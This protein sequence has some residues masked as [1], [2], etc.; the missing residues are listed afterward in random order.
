MVKMM[1]HVGKLK[2]T[3]TRCVV[4]LMQIP[5]KEDHALIVESDS[6]PDHYH[7]NLM[8]VLESREGQ[9]Q[10]N[11]ADE[12]ARKMM[13]IASRGNMPVLQALH[14][15]K[16]LRAESVDNITMVPAPGSA[17]PLRQILESMGNLKPNTDT[18]LDPRNNPNNPRFNP[19]THNLEGNTAKDKLE[20]AKGIIMQAQLMEADAAKLRA[21]AYAIAPELREQYGPV[22]YV[23]A[24]SNK[25][26][27]TLPAVDN[28]DGMEMIVD[29]DPKLAESLM[30]L[31][32]EVS[33]T[34]KK[35]AAKQPNKTGTKP[36]A[37]R[38]PSRKSTA[39]KTTK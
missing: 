34:M 20:A 35:P 31:T 16:F 10:T 4:V 6:L 7:Q 38:A 9:N 39:P 36:A 33:E 23:Q 19:H 32:E 24:S 3:D 2:A 1:R 29:T 27:E 17:H 30:Q 21:Q 11:L 5:N 26:S 12:L 13:F 22:S 28:T 15:A 18:V 37:K 25:M 14:E 8:E